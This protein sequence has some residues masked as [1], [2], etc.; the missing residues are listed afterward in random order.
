MLG[1]G[2]E[3]YSI[4]Q[5]GLQTPVVCPTA[6]LSSDTVFPVITANSTGEGLGPTEYCRPRLLTVLLIYCSYSRGF[7]TSS[8]GSN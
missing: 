3:E 1:V 7:Q 5:A 4:R 8:I 2:G 6:H